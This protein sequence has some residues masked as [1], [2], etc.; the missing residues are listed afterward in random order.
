QLREGT[1]LIFTKGQ[2][3]DGAVVTNHAIPI[4][5]DTSRKLLSANPGDKRGLVE[6]A[7]PGYGK[8]QVPRKVLVPTEDSGLNASRQGAEPVSSLSIYFYAE[9]EVLDNL[10]SQIGWSLRSLSL[11]YFDRMDDEKLMMA[12]LKWC[13]KLTKLSISPDAINLNRLVTT[14]ENVTG[15]PKPR[16]SSL[17]LIRISDIGADH[18][19]AFAEFLG[20]PRSRLTQHFEELTIEAFGNDPRVTGST[21]Q[22][23]W[24]APKH[25]TK[26]RKLKLIVPSNVL[27][28]WK[29]RF[30]QFHCQVLPPVPVDLPSKLA[31]LSASCMEG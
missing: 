5:V 7:L 25:N 2:T 19:V 16:I 6:V 23:L 17:S 9:A 12:I 30:R 18:G 11:Q 13:P 3:S 4:P 28:P 31:F 22:A 24:I 15:G 21:M 8:C 29:N 27:K 10:L 26:L 20:D 14:Y 1:Q